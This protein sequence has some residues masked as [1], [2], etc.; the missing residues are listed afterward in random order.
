M[1]REMG[2]RVMFILLRGF[3]RLIVLGDED[4]G[5]G[6][7]KEVSKIVFLIDPWQYYHAGRLELR[8]KGGLSG[9]IV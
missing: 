7:E 4:E 1:G 8:Y 2:F 5:K 9:A 3:V 6:K